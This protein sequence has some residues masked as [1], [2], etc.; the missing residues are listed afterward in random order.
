MVTDVRVAGRGAATEGPADATSETE[1]QELMQA[2]E[3]RLFNFVARLVGNREDAEEIVQDTFA[4]AFRALQ[5][6]N[7]DHPIDPTAAWFYTI[8]LNTVRNR[9]RRRRIATVALD[10]E[11]PAGGAIFAH[12]GPGPDVLVE[13]RETWQQIQGAIARLP[14]HQRAPVILRF[15]NELTYEEIATI[16]GCPVGTAKSHVHRGVQRLRTDLAS[17]FAREGES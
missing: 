11:H 6:A 3:D 16:V 14:I 8:A 4:K 13:R 9:V 7:G 17:V 10:G 1:F 15:V 12:Q 5:R 2:H